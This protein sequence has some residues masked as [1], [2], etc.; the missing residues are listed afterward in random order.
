MNSKEWEETGWTRVVNPSKE[1]VHTKTFQRT[2]FTYINAMLSV[3][4]NRRILAEVLQVPFED[5][6]GELTI[7]VDIMKHDHTTKEYQKYLKE[8]KK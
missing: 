7:T 5:L 4:N 2:L 6:L 8:E 3:V 1:V